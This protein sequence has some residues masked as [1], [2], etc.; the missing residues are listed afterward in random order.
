MIS[1]WTQNTPLL[2]SVFSLVSLIC[3][4]RTKLAFG[5]EQMRS[6]IA[7]KSQFW[8]SLNTQRFALATEN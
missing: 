1:K 2:I 5:L 4:G 8:N 3:T 7:S 6:T